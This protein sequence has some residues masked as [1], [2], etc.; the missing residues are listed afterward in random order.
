MTWTRRRAY[1]AKHHKPTQQ[2]NSNL[3]RLNARLTALENGAVAGEGNQLIRRKVFNNRHAVFFEDLD[4]RIAA[5]EMGRRVTHPHEI[6]G[7]I[8]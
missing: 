7:D 3:Q 4:S 5:L 2:C 1:L 6:W 8:K